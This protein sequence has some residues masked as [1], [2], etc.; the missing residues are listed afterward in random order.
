MPPN[1]EHYAALVKAAYPKIKAA[2]P[3]A[4]VIT[5]VV[6]S[7]GG[8]GGATAL[9][10]AEFLSRMYAAGARGYFDAIGSHPYGFANSPATRNANNVTDFRRA[11]DQY[12]VMVENGDGHKAI[13]ATEFGWLLNPADFGRPELLDDPAWSGRIWQR[14]SPELQAQYL[15]EAYQYAR[16]NWP[17][18]GAMFLFNTDY[19]TVPWYSDAD[20]IRWYSI[21]NPDGSPRPAYQALRDMPK[22]SP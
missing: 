15:V 9:D 16:Q 13:W 14:V 5:G 6:A 7:T 11:A 22:P 4:M 2:D 8:D 3:A 18:M 12:Q 21:L 1:P 10:D 19:S 20:P 17:W